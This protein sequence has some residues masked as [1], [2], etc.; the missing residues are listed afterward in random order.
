M[1]YVAVFSNGEKLDL[2]L[3][4][5]DGTRFAIARMKPMQSSARLPQGYQTENI[6]KIEVFIE[7]SDGTVYHDSF[8]FT[9]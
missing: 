1:R 6:E 2:P 5:I 3:Q 8:D 7:V 4:D 9:K